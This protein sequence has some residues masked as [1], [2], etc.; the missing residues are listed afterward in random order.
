MQDNY[1]TGL[2]VH[3]LKSPLFASK[4]INGREINKIHTADTINVEAANQNAVYVFSVHAK[5]TR[6]HLLTFLL[7]TNARKN[8]KLNAYARFEVIMEV[9]WIMA[10][11]CLINSKV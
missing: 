5:F 4:K 3:T 11:Y 9:P 1:K 2:L 10:P 8:C 6:T 7:D